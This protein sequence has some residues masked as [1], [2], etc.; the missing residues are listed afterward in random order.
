MGHTNTHRL[1]RLLLV[2]LALT[3][4]CQSTYG[5]NIRRRHT[6]AGSY[7]SFRTPWSFQ[8]A[9]DEGLDNDDLH[10][11]RLSLQHQLTKFN[12]FRFNLGLVE[13]DSDFD[14][15]VLFHG[16]GYSFSFDRSRRINID[17]V[18]LSFQY[19][20]NPSRSQGINFFWGAG[21][22]FSVSD[23][24]SDMTIFY[25]TGYPYYF[26]DVDIIES[27]RLGFGL[28]ASVG[29]E[30]FLGRNFSLLAEYGLIIENQWYLV[31]VDYY[32]DYGYWYSE[33]DTFNDGIH[34]DASRIKLGCAFHF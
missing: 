15:D 7:D 28:D 11:I 13:K 3:F 8:V 26:Q 5:I 33:Y 31:D 29:M 4:L 19:M 18:N 9:L 12:A 6:G 1:F 22:R 20:F 23:Q 16:D 30:F 17:E 34:V 2:T 27:T 25:D 32:D 14:D 24:N 10:G 21:P